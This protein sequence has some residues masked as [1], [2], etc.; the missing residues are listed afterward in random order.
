MSLGSFM[1]RL[2]AL[3][4]V[5]LGASVKS[6]EDAVHDPFSSAAGTGGML[7]KI[8]GFGHNDNGHAHGNGLYWGV[9]DMLELRRALFWIAAV[10]ILLLIGEDDFSMCPNLTKHQ[11]R[12]RIR[13]RLPSVL[14]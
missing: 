6:Q 1:G 9:V 8:F 7:G 5:H 12:S 11:R 14:T 2:A 3:T 13:Q 10:V 4:G